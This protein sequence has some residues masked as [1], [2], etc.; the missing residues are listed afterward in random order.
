VSRDVGVRVPSSAPLLREHTVVRSFLFI[1]MN[2]EE[3]QIYALGVFHGR[4][5]CAQSVL[6]AYTD[7]L[8]LDRDHLE[9]LGA[10]FG[11]GAGEGEICGAV[12][13]ALMVLGLKFGHSNLLPENKDRIKEVSRKFKDQFQHCSGSLKCRELTGFD[14]RFQEGQDKAR[15]AGVFQTTCPVFIRDAIAIIDQLLAEYEKNPE[16]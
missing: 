12:S 14:L 9:K 8:A 10:A 7:E 6:S 5:N 15:A 3:K 11:S 4:L 2:T 13:G 16:K 1:G